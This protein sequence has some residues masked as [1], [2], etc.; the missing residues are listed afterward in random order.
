MKKISPLSIF[1][2]LCTLASFA[3]MAGGGYLAYDNLTEDNWL[4]FG[5]GCGIA[6]LGIFLTALFVTLFSRL[7]KQADFADKPVSD[8]F[9]GAGLFTFIA[10]FLVFLA[11]GLYLWLNRGIWLIGV[12]SI[13][14]FILMLMFAM[15]LSFRHQMAPIKK[16]AADKHAFEMTGK[17][18]SISAKWSIIVLKPVVLI[19]QYVIETDHV[20]SVAYCSWR[21]PLKERIKV[22][23]E[24][25]VQMNPNEPQYCLLIRKHVEPKQQEETTKEL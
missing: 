17:V 15:I 23:D 1:F 9:K 25:V 3:G 8:C 6:L 14:C 10:A 21:N 13:A 19:W 24:V 11:I 18:T 5:I 16:A 7:D 22:G 12:I 2:K 4:W 20:K